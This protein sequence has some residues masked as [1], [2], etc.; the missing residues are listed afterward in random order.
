MAVISEIADPN[1]APRSRLTVKGPVMAAIVGMTERRLRQLATEG[2]PKEGR[3]GYPLDGCVQWIIDYWRKRATQTPLGAAR[4]RKLEADASAAEIDLAVKR[5]AVADVAAIAR[6]HG[7]SCARIRTRL[8]AIP[9]KTAPQ[10]H[11][12]KT[13]PEVQAVMRREIIEA[14]EELAGGT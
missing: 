7:E 3:E 12:L 5:G 8:L 6:V 11:R 14:L 4:R 13:V 2:M 1:F 9:S 10:I